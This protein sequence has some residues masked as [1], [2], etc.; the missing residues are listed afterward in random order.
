MARFEFKLPDIGEGV[1]EGEIVSWHVRPGELVAEDQPVVEV[2]TDKATVTIGAPKAGRIVETRGAVGEIVNVNSVLVVFDV[3][4]HAAGQEHGDN[5]SAKTDGEST[6]SAVG[7]LREHLPGM[8]PARP[9]V[10][11][12]SGRMDKPLATPAI[13]KMAREL[14]VDLAVVQGSGPD[15]RVTEADVRAAAAGPAAAGSAPAPAAVVAPP[16]AFRSQAEERFALKGV[17]KKSFENVARSK[18]TAAHFTV[19]EECDVS[20]LKALRDHLKGP[21]AEQG[22]KLTFLPFIMKAVLYALRR[23]PILNATFDEATQEIVV[24]HYFNI[25]IA[26]ATENGLLVPVVKNVDKLALLDVARE[27][28]R[29]ADEARSG[30][31]KVEDLAG[32]TFTITSL[33]DRGG[34]FATP[35]IHYPEVAILGI[36]RMK[37]KP[38]VRGGQ[39]VI[40]DVMLMSLSFDHR[41]I[42][43]DAAAAFTYDFIGSLERP[44]ALLLDMA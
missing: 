35:I 36:H 4:G 39:I 31:I 5:G 26:T 6:A 18:H 38:V 12:R 22:V 7:D 27:I 11:T 3:D 9:G 32:G 16:V 42:D 41:L 10:Q 44:E 23:H 14:G 33:G 17:R 20:A 43:G 37:Q 34:L 40:G 29:L 21:A 25:G 19:V 15:G 1:Y 28:L 30:R 2:M 8:G 13:R 24:R